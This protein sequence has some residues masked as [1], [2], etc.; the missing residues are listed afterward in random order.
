MKM[1]TACARVML[2]LFATACA[3][4]EPGPK[5]ETGSTA[6]TNAQPCEE[7]PTGS[8]IRRCG[9]ADARVMTREDV[10][11]SGLGTVRNPGGGPTQ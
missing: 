8:R 7:A 9:P 6:A 11:R 1:P 4:V 2:C 3:T 5:G 10:E